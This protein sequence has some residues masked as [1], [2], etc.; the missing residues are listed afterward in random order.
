MKNKNLKYYIILVIIWTIIFSIIII[1]E[2]LLFTENSIFTIA[3]LWLG[4]IIFLIVNKKKKQD[5]II[6]QNKSLIKLKNKNSEQQKIIANITEV[7]TKLINASEQLNS[8]S[9]QISEQ[10]NTQA[11]TTDNIA[12]SM[13]QILSAIKL[14]TKNAEIT[15]EK[16]TKSANAL[17]E[18]KASFDKT[19]KSVSDISKETFIISD[20]SFQTNILSLNASIEAARAGKYGKGFA[21]VAEE[22]RNLAEKSKIATEKI[23]EL[24]ENGKNISRIAGEKFEKIIPEILESAELIDRILQQNIKQK[25]EI[26]EIN[27]SIQQLS[28]V[29]I[30]SSVSAEEMSM[31]ANDLSKQAKE[32]K[33]IVLK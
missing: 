9:E 3:T 29:T 10:A 7:S 30:D 4:G 25:N 26:E 11:V 31:L 2:K 28:E 5:K 33:N 21:V 12:S 13:E 20:I 23:E 27:N 17:Q 14:N 19:I 24:S 15:A 8:A 18:N 16:T 1:L 22:V 6:E 32:L